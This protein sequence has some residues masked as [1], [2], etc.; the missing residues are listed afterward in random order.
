MPLRKAL[1]RASAF[2]NNAASFVNETAKRLHVRKL[3]LSMNP[4]AAGVLGDN[5]QMSLDEVPVRQD[6]TDDTRSHIMMGGYSVVGG[7]GALHGPSVGKVLSFNRGDLVLDPDE[8]FF[9]NTNDASG[10]PG[11]SMAVNVWYED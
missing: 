10:T 4:T 9:L 1:L 3:V 11:L 2:Q 5:A 6:G 7:T 8:A